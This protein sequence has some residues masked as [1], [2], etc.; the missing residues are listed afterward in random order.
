MITSRFSDL[1]FACNSVKTLADPRTSIVSF[2]SS[3]SFSGASA[4]L[5][6]RGPSFSTRDTLAQ[7][8][9]RNLRSQHVETIAENRR[10][11]GAG[12]VPVGGE[13]DLDGHGSSPAAALMS[14]SGMRLRFLCPLAQSPARDRVRQD[15]APETAPRS[16]I[17]PVSQTGGRDV[18]GEVGGRAARRRRA[19]SHRPAVS[20]AADDAR[21]LRGVA[22]YSI[23][24]CRRPSLIVQSMVGP[25]RAT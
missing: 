2:S 4:T 17:S 7:P 15:P 6:T 22:L 16:V 10:V 20:G 13:I 5:S 18:E 9:R 14:R 11:V 25:G 24:I 21:H 1:I 23:G 19:Q 8:T 12:H 3:F